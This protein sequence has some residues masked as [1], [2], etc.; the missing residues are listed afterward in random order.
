MD[1]DFRRQVFNS[2]NMRDTEDLLEIWQ[3]NNRAEWEQVAFDV[4][5]EILQSRLGTAPPQGE[6]SYEFSEPADEESDDL[7]QEQQMIELAENEDVDELAR[8]LRNEPDPLKCLRAAHTLAQLNDERG[9]DYLIGALNSVDTATQRLAQQYLD[10]LNSVAPESLPS[11]KNATKPRE[12]K[13][14]NQRCLSC[15]S[16]R[17]AYGNVYTASIGRSGHI[18]SLNQ[19]NHVNYPMF[20]YVCLDC[21]TVGHYLADDDLND[22]RARLPK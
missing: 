15:Q 14:L 6:P 16:Q 5:A 2:L 12:L 10:A 7:D 18:F 4:I 17:L 21:G 20:A 19:I 8:I 3:E 9:M 13:S 1:S 22:L 11:E